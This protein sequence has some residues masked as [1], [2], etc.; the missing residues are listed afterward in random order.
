[1]SSRSPTLNEEHSGSSGPI[2]GRVYQDQP[3]STGAELENNNVNESPTSTTA[4]Q[5]GSSNDDPEKQ[6][7]EGK[8][9]GK[10]WI[11]SFDG[12]HDPDNPRSMSKGRKWAITM[13]V[14]FSSLC[15]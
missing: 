4:H 9:P 13:V 14:A 1:M 8:D 6:Q 3:V 5:P 15:V 12:D 2:A 11:V 7:L 10:E